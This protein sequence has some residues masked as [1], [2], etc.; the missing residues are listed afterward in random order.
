MSEAF[1]V[2]SLSLQQLNAVAAALRGTL[3]PV[4]ELSVVELSIV[5]LS[6]VELSIVESSVVESSVVESSVAGLSVAGLSVAGLSVAEASVA[7]LQSHLAGYSAVAV[8]LYPAVRSCQAGFPQVMAQ[9]YPAHQAAG[10]AP[11]PVLPQRSC[12]AP[13]H[14]ATNPLSS[15]L[16]HLQATRPASIRRRPTAAHSADALP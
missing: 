3:E 6:V 4:V 9:P 12:P 11:R 1:S 2:V 10:R 14:W 15:A 13:A 8:L 5:E 16:S 7:E